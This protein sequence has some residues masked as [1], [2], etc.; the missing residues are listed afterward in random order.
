MGVCLSRPE[1]L[2]YKAEVATVPPPSHVGSD[3]H[4]SPSDRV[5]ASHTRD[6]SPA[7]LRQKEM[8]QSVSSDAESSTCSLSKV[9]SV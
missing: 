7:M 5:T 6:S 4:S 1:S 3:K 9:G 8:S 2:T